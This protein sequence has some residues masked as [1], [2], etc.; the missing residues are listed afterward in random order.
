MELAKGHRCGDDGLGGSRRVAESASETIEVHELFWVRRT[1][2]YAAVGFCH[3][4]CFALCGSALLSKFQNVFSFM[5][6]GL[7]LIFDVVQAE[8]NKKLG[9]LTQSLPRCR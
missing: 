3:V 7:P 6:E 5:V 2:S 9:F 1:V 4:L 8:L